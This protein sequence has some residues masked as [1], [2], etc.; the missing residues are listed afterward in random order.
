TVT[1]GTG[2]DSYRGLAGYADAPNH[3]VLYSTRKGG[4]AAAGGGELVS[5]ADISG[6]GGDD[7]PAITILA[8]A[9]ANT[10]FRGVAL[11]PAGV[12]IPVAGGGSYAGLSYAAAA[13]AVNGVLGTAATLRAGTDAGAATVVSLTPR[14]RLPGE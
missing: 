5:L 11:A 8:T 12:N 7:S 14:I 2:A 1:Y 3:V 10:A 9:A 13:N 4:G 6:Y